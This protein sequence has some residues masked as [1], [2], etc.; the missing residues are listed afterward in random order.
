MGNNLERE[1]GLFPLTNIVIAN[2]VGSGMFLLPGM[3]MAG[4]RDPVLMIIL[5]LVGGLIALCGALCYSELAAAI[6]EAGGEYAFLSRLVHPAAGFL[7]GWVSLIVGFSAPIAAS[8]IG[9]V[10]YFSRPFPQMFHLGLFDPSTEEILL[11]K[12]F[13][14]LVIVLFTLIH[15]RGIVFGTHVQNYLTIFKIALIVGLIGF[16]LSVGDGD[17]SHFSQRDTFDFDLSGWK[18]IGLS[19]M[20]I[21]FAYSG[22]NASTYI[23]SE[24]RKPTRTLPLSLI[25]GTTTV[26]ALY[27][28]FNAFLVYGIPPDEMGGVISVGGLAARNLFGVSFE[29]LFSVLIS[30]AVLSSLS[31][32][33]ILGPRV[34]YAMAKDGQ[35]FS[36]AA[37][38]H[39]EYRVPS[40]SI[41]F[42]CLIAVVIVLSGTFDQILTYMGFSLG[43]FPILAVLSVFKLRRMKKSKYRMPGYPFIPIVFVVVGV[44]SLVLSFMERPGPS[45]VAILTVAAGVP[46]YFAFKRMASR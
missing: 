6:P 39:D 34:Y 38:V 24:I 23:G 15:R 44:G 36:F 32:F 27:L 28:G 3:L 29:N 42:Q 25:I 11:K 7:S 17:V 16:G 12:L 41:G 8:A 37:E 35:F 31:A 20:W 13:A 2:M 14:V 21:M 10:E 33:I 1:L 45:S 9:F 46:A 40:K 43:I 5:W 30:L 22:W 18:T 4:L 26:I 19:L